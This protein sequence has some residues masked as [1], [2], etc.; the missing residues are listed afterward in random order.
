MV[1]NAG[2]PENIQQTKHIMVMNAGFLEN[3]KQAKGNNAVSTEV[4]LRFFP[5]VC[6]FCHA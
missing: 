2:F 6:P 1:M 5:P 3:I 4:L